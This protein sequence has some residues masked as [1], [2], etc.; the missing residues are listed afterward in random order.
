MFDAHEKSDAQNNHNTLR[1]CH[2]KKKRAIVFFRFLHH[3]PLFVPLFFFRSKPQN[4]IF[5]AKNC[6][7]NDLSCHFLFFHHL[8]LFL[9]KR[10]CLSEK[11]LF[12]STFF[13]FT[14]PLHSTWHNCCTGHSGV[15][16]GMM[17]AIRQTGTGPR[18]MHSGPCCGTLPLPLP[19]ALRG[20]GSVVL[21]L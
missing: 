20:V 19:V 15:M 6:A 17:R 16:T 13:L 18:P 21:C 8:T 4:D 14:G 10:P 5:D 7:N 9:I 1:G 2:P 3:L 11:T 12:S